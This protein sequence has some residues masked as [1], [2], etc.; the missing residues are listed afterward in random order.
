MERFYRIAGLDF[1]VLAPDDEYYLDDGALAN[2]RTVAAAPFRDV[3]LELVDRLDPPEGELSASAG[4]NWIYQGKDGLLRY[5][6]CISGWEGAY[7]RII[8]QESVSR[9][10]VLRHPRESRFTHN[11]ALEAMELGHQLIQNGGFLLHASYIDCGGE[12][13]LFTAPPGTGKSTQAELWCRLRDAELINGDR[14]AVMMSAH[15]AKAC[16][17]PYAGLSKVRKNRTLPVKAIVC[18]SQAKSTSIRRLGGLEAFR[19][20]WEGCSVD[21]WDREDMNRCA[22]SLTELLCHVPVYHLACTPD[23]SAI[24]ALEEAMRK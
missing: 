3:Y 22:Q 1:R 11:A 20:L 10:Q 18:L 19:S 7:M 17:V 4:G 6:G 9:V 8:R 12:A 5:L 23:E 16:G 14:A 15:G 13:I 24:L 21:T 2:F